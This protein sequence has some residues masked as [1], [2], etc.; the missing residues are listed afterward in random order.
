[1]NKICKKRSNKYFLDYVNKNDVHLK[2]YKMNVNCPQ[3]HFKYFN[4]NFWK[5]FWMSEKHLT[6]NDRNNA[7]GVKYMLST[8]RTP[9]TTHMNVSLTHMWKSLQPHTR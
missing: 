5:Q 8:K 2:F 4:I 7:V 1:M 6:N 3:Y 9:S